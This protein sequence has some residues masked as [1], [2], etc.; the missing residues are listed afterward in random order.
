M[1]WPA[2]VPNSLSAP[3][4]ADQ[5]CQRDTLSK[6]AS[7]QRKEY[8]DKIITAESSDSIVHFKRSDIQ[9]CNMATLSEITCLHQI[10]LVPASVQEMAIS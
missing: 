3:F 10:K 5:N 2:C 9:A 7:K 1:T 6:Q 4:L 8:M